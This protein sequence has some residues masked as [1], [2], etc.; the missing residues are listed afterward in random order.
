M[1]LQEP[2][3][4]VLKGV[5][6]RNVLYDVHHMGEVLLWKGGDKQ[7]IQNSLT[8]DVSG[9]ELGLCEG[10]PGRRLRNPE[11]GQGQLAGWLGGTASIASGEWGWGRNRMLP[12]ALATQ[13]YRLQTPYRAKTAPTAKTQLRCW[14]LLFSIL[15]LMKMCRLHVQYTRDYHCRRQQTVSFGVKIYH[16]STHTKGKQ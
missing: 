13:L 7:V 16:I 8:C 9:P 10:E 6:G 11:G 1:G 2:K 12:R 15:M 4:E 5:D 14:S 3:L